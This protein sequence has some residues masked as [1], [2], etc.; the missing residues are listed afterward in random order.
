[1]RKYCILGYGYNFIDVLK[2]AYFFRIQH[3]FILIITYTIYELAIY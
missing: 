1:M 3:F 2:E